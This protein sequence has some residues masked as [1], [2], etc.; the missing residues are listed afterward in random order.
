MQDLHTAL[1]DV[2]KRSRGGHCHHWFIGELTNSLLPLREST[3]VELSMIDSSVF[4]SPKFMLRLSDGKVIRCRL[5]EQS[6]YASF[7]SNEVICSIAKPPSCILV[8]VAFA[9]GGPEAIT[10]SFY[11]TMRAQQQPAGG[12]ENDTL[13]KR[14]KLS[15]CLPS[16]INWDGIIND[17]IQTY[18]KGDDH[19]KPHRPNICLHFCTFFSEKL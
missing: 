17:T 15:W 3:V 6:V 2:D 19:I 11:A 8:D 16:H 7:Y 18:L 12:Q 4:F 10:E 1:H 13:V 5:H 9:K 14:S